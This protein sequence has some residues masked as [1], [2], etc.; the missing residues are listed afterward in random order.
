LTQNEINFLNLGLNCHYLSKI[1]NFKINKTIEIEKLMYNINDLELRKLVT[2]DPSIAHELKVESNKIR[3]K[4]NST[5]LT[6]DLK[7]AATQLK[8]NPNIEI[9]KSDKSNMY[10]ILNKNDYLN[11][12]N[13]I[14]NDKKKFKQIKYDPTT[15]LKT[16]LNKL[17]NQI[18]SLIPDNKISKLAG[19]YKPGYI[20]GNVKT[21]K[22]NNPLR[23][24]ISQIPTVT[25]PIA[26]FLKTVL[27]PYTPND[28]TIKSSF[29]LLDILK[30]NEPDK[31][32][33]SLDVESLFTNVPVKDTINI[34][35]NTVYNSNMNP[36]N[37]P[38]N[39][40]KS[41]LEICT[42][43]A[44]FLS[45]DGKLYKQIDGVAMGSPLGVLF[46]NFYM[47]YVEN[48]IFNTFPEL[49]PKIYMRYVDD[50]FISYNEEN[51]KEQ[52]IEQFHLNSKLNFTFENESNKKLPFL[53]ILVEHTDTQFITSVYIK[54]TNSGFCLNGLSECSHAYKLSTIRSLVNRAFTHSNNETQLHSELNR[55][56]KLLSNNN[57]NL[58]DINYIINSKFEKHK[59]ANNNNNANA[60]QQNDTN[61][62]N[63]NIIIYYKNYMSTDYKTDEQIIKKIIKKNVK[64]NDDENKLC[65]RIFY[66]NKRT[67]NL[68]LK[69]NCHPTP[70]NSLKKSHLIYEFKCSIDECAHQ[71]NSYIGMTTTSLSR[72]LTMHKGDGAIKKH[73]LEHNIP[74]TRQLLTDNTKILYENNNYFNLRLAE[75]IFIDKLK[76]KINIQQQ[77]YNVLPTHKKLNNNLTNSNIPINYNNN[78]NNSANTNNN[79]NI[80]NDNNNSINS[81]NNI[82]VII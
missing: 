3:G 76:P 82:N 60:L 63:H 68:I 21:H 33:G 71:I 19:E 11:K 75:S 24:I 16:R 9:R 42:T 39:I 57:Y 59:D 55:V 34:I 27:T 15:S 52:L 20:Y 54:K 48:S 22:E 14:L 29:E 70:T 56:R 17:I 7:Q 12:L 35:L 43:E 31:F 74:I 41:L 67:S 46:S 6:E 81:D 23:P 53:D 66:K 26:K 45:P 79:I 49:K 50:I 78:I 38:K 8:N 61:N 80:I 28:Y 69:N 25:Y 13:I 4:F 73:I 64:P 36:L 51:K 1:K 58:K 2:V 47:G 65:I 77:I 10:V 18:N 40:L 44:P 30:N 72:R 37:I 5:I 32:I 62:I